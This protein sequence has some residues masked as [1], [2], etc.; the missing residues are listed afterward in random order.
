V[1]AVTVNAVLLLAVNVNVT[2]PGF[3]G[4][5]ITTGVLVYAV[6]YV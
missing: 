5:K 3:T 6:A 2:A 4:V 1:L